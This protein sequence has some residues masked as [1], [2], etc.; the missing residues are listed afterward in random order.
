MCVLAAMAISVVG[1]TSAEAGQIRTAFKN[2]SPISRA[3]VTIRNGD[4]INLEV[5]LHDG[6]RGIPNKLI[7]FYVTINKKQV[8]VGQAVTDRN[9]RAAVNPRIVIPGLV[10]RNWIPVNW[11][12]SFTGD[13]KYMSAQNNLLGTGFRVLP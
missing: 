5:T 9:G 7:K 8:L 12:P 10:G 1:S 11:V 6:S 2:A 4:R 3:G 13:S